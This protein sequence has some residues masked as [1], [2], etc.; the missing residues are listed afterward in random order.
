MGRVD[1]EEIQQGRTDRTGGETPGPSATG[2]RQG[3]AL[4]VEV[5]VEGGDAGV[6]DENIRTVL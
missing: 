6:A 3:G 1:L 5:L 4:Q 2:L